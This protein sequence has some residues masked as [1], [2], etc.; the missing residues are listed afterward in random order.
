MKKHLFSIMAIACLALTSVSMVGCDSTTEVPTPSNPSLESGKCVITANVSGS[1]TATYKSTDMMSPVLRQTFISMNSSFSGALSGNPALV[2][3]F[4]IYLPL[5][6]AVGSYNSEDFPG[7]NPA[8]FTYSYTNGSSALG[9]TSGGNETS[10]NF[11]VT[12][13]TAEEIEGTFEGT[14]GE[15]ENGTDVAVNGTFKAKF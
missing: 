6:I 12:K 10:I 15:E 4:I 7:S 14:M 5:D 2:Q 3:Q 8:I 9:W 13:S 11:K 1:H